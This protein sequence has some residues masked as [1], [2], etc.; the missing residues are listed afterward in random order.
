LRCR[1]L[2]K[3]TKGLI[4]KAFMNLFDEVLLA[5]WFRPKGLKAF[6]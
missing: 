4:T 1:L 3:S 5:Q 2:A 6:M